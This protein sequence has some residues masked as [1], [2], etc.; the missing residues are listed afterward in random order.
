MEVLLAACTHALP[1]IF[2]ARQGALVKLK[3]ANATPAGANHALMQDGEDNKDSCGSE[4][5]CD[6]G[7]VILEQP[8]GHQRGA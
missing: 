3:H 2:Q 6:V 5:V 7:R 1:A 4:K 8:D